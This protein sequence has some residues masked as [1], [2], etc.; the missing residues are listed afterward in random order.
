M[1]PCWRLSASRHG[2]GWYPYSPSGVT[3][4]TFSQGQV[5]DLSYPCGVGQGVTE[6]RLAVATEIEGLHVPVAGGFEVLGYSND[7]L[8]DNC[9]H[10]IH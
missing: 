5:F 7:L 8:R 4:W 6:Y 3:G 1:W 9:G 2:L 10:G